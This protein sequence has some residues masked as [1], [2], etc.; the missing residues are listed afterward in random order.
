M[1]VGFSLTSPLASGGSSPYTYA[2]HVRGKD[3]ARYEALLRSHLEE[4]SAPSLHSLRIGVVWRKDLWCISQNH[5][6]S[7]LTVCR[8]AAAPSAPSSARRSADTS[9]DS[10]Q[11]LT[12]EGHVAPG[13]FDEARFRRSVRGL[14]EIE[15]HLKKTCKL[16]M[17]GYGARPYQHERSL[18]FWTSQVEVRTFWSEL[19]RSNPRIGPFRHSHALGGAVP[20]QPR[21]V[22]VRVAR[23]MSD[24]RSHQKKTR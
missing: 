12:C 14:G 19:A 21:R 6:E 13:I 17:A 20:P 7:N 5:D 11:V 16:E 22:T 1:R 3:H 2:H 8:R 18:N 15:P 10:M 23:S 9:D 4:R 24:G